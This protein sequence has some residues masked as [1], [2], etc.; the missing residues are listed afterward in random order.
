MNELGKIAKYIRSKNASPFL[1]TI[2]VFFSD[3]SSYL[4]VKQSGAINPTSIAELYNLPE[5]YIQGIFWHDGVWGIKITIFKNGFVASGD[6]ECADV[7]GAQQYIPI[8]SLSIPS[9]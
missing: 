7:F 9:P 5:E 6:P 8:L 3:F 2:D 4:Q 1:T